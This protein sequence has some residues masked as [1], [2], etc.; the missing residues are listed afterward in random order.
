[1]TS[2]KIKSIELKSVFAELLLNIYIDKEPRMTIQKPNL[3]RMIK[4]IS[5]K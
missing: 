2:S 1:M 3:V 4:K 5:E